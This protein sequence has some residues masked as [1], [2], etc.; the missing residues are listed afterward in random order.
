MPLLSTEEV[1]SSILGGPSCFKE[2]MFFG[3][4]QNRREY[5]GTEKHTHKDKIFTMIELTNIPE[6]EKSK[7]DFKALVD[8]IRM[9]NFQDKKNLMEYINQ[10]MNAI[11]EWLKENNSTGVQTVRLMAAKVARLSRLQYWKKLCEQYL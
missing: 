8:T 4:F 10:E 9:H 3:A 2:L 7:G 11:S 1:P 6:S 5:P